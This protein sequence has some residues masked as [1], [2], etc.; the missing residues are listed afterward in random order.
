MKKI[1]VSV[2]L[3]AVLVFTA[4]AAD[5]NEIAEKW[6]Q[7]KPSFFDLQPYEEKPVSGEGW[8]AG[9][10]KPGFV[11][12]GVN[13]LNFC[14]FVAGLDEVSYNAE[15]YDEM[16]KAALLYSAAVFSDAESIPPYMNEDFYRQGYNALKKSLTSFGF[17]TLD[18]SVSG[19]INSRARNMQTVLP[20]TILLSPALETVSFG[21]FDGY[22]AVS[23]KEA[24][25]VHD[26]D[27]VAWP[28]SGDFPDTL[29]KEN[30]PWSITLDPKKYSVPVLEELV[31]RLDNVKTDKTIELTGKGEYSYYNSDDVYVGVNPDTY[32]VIF[33]PLAQDAEIWSK[34]SEYGIHVTVFGIKTADGQETSIQYTVNIFNLDDVILGG[35]SDA[36]SVAAHHK[37]AV[38]DMTASGI[39]VG[40]PDGTFRPHDEITRAEFTVT[41]LRYLGIQPSQN[42]EVVFSD[43][44]ADHWAKGYIDKAA[45]IGAV[46]GTDPGIFSPDETVTAEQAMKIVTIVKDFTHN[47]NVEASGGYP[48][49]YYNLG[50]ELGLL[51]FVD[52]GEA[53]DYPLKRSDTARILYNTSSITKFWVEKTLDRTVIWHRDRSGKG[54][55]YYSF[56]KFGAN[57]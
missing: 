2:L 4:Y 54:Y 33:K 8:T 43:V 41:L 27:Y 57:N 23:T 15:Q 47:M 35:Y 53:F 30:I 28:A 3:C 10:L 32:T 22:A 31:I 34:F 50:Y 7:L 42:E 20:R 11:A 18:L 13:Y 6:K 17:D 44:T 21:F 14:R 38:A 49:A 36:K 52:D 26:Y 46:N 16:Q 55:G 5:K 24:E 48:L 37:N 19:L 9:R 25:E 1:L 40:Y 12:D 45:E 29:L 56:V 51:D 39:F